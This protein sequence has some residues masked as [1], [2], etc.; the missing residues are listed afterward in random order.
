MLKKI[1]GKN[2]L[3]ELN[4]SQQSLS[5]IFLNYP[6]SQRDPQKRGN[7]TT[8]I[9]NVLVSENPNRLFSPWKQ[10][11]FQR[12]PFVRSTSNIHNRTRHVF[13]T[14]SISVY[15][16]RHFLVPVLRDCGDSHPY[17]AAPN[18]K[19]WPKQKIIIQK[20]KNINRDPRVLG[21]TDQNFLNV[22]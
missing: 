6:K 5:Y 2:F 20:M 15:K 18:W 10:V 4:E 3:T 17:S 19:W 9:S 16:H 8:S 11:Q 14:S 22:S 13:V 1:Y 7:V 21:F 12:N